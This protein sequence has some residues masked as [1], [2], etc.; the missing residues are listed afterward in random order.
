MPMLET[1]E[2]VAERYGVTR[3]AQDVY[4]LQSQERTAAAQEAERFYAEI[5]AFEATMTVKDRASGEVSRRE[6]TLDR[7][8]G[9]RPGTTLHSFA[10]LSPVI[11]GGTVTAGSASQLS[12]GASACVLM[13]RGEAERQ[14]LTPMGT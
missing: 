6:V 12:D 13:E 1:A 14:G 8:E 10:G 9:N 4:A 3:E 7:D 2:I 11:E 5:V